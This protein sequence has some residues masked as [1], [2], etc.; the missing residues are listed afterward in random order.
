MYANKRTTEPR[1]FI[2]LMSAIIIS[3]ILLTA[4][5]SGSL[6]GFYT[7]FNILDS[8]FKQ[9]SSALADACVD[10][11]LSK[12]VADSTYAGPS[13]NYPVGSDTCS[14]FASTNP[15]GSPRNF[16]VQGKYQNSYTNLQV[17][18]DVSTLVVTSWQEVA[19]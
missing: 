1:G 15:T 3:A 5:I 17:A 7:R 13:T 6:S 12:L 18:V 9:R 16:K 11:L 10:V 19:N 4:T 14:I 2:A 8:E